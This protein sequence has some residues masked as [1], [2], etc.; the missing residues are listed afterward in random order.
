MNKQQV[1]TEYQKLVSELGELPHHV[2]LS[3]GAALVMMGIRKDTDD[4][5]VDVQPGV[6][7]WAA[8]S[9]P[10]VVE[11]NISPRVKWADKVDLHEFSEN[12]GIVCIEGVWVYSPGEML[13]QKRHLASIPN[14][15]F[16]KR[17]KD[18]IEIV[19]L[20]SLRRDSR[21]TARMA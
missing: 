16:G 19:Q 18:L 15:A 8:L 6:Y 21:L 13:N 20:E 5:D 1:I 9:K 17:E 11:D 3:A 14:R 7:K 10:T 4:L 12:T 2:V